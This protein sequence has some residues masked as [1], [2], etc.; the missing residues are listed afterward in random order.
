MVEKKIA[1]TKQEA[2]DFLANHDAYIVAG[3][4]DLMVVKKNVA[5]YAPT[6]DR[7]VLYISHIKELA[8][9]YEDKE[10]IHIGATAT[11]S[12]I[13]NHPLCPSLL[14]KAISEVAST[15]IRHFCTLAG[16]IANASPAGDTSVVD[17]LLDAKI[18]LESA[19]GV[20]FVDA[21]DFVQGVRRIDRHPNEL[22][23]ELIFPKISYTDEMWFK[24]GSRKADSISKVSVAGYYEVQKG[25]VTKFAVCFGSVSIKPARSK[26]L[27][28]K[29][30]GLTLDEVKAKQPQIAGDFATIIA[31]IDDQRS[32]KEYR[33]KVAMNIFNSFLEKMIGGAK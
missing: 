29:V 14:R 13:E 3:G 8:K 32:N 16:N 11:M 26:G 30:V 22:I 19:D 15:N 24:V 2:L 12:E 1:Y 18:K 23:T 33:Q 17:V 28:A 4:S 31:P 5:G 27:E 20:R 10:G 7:D 9:I 21:Q 25:V 6:F